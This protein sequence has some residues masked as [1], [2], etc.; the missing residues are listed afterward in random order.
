[1]FSFS[2]Q[3]ELHPGEKGKARL[4]TITTSHGTIQ[5][6]AFVAVGTKGTVKSLSPAQVREAGTQVALANTY[7]MYLEPGAEVVR[8]RGRT[9]QVYALGRTDN[10]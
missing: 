4:G 2:I 8:E 5:T 1:M 3:K 10:D 7:H 6:P 9:W